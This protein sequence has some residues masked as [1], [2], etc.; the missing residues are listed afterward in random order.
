MPDLWSRGVAQ[1]MLKCIVL[2]LVFILVQCAASVFSRYPAV[3][4][5]AD[6]S[7]DLKYTKP[8][9][10]RSIM[11]IGNSTTRLAPKHDEHETLKVN[12]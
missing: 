4:K 1:A 11:F 6:Q 9:R 5:E 3:S 2:Y 12:F 10:Q 7:L 8:D